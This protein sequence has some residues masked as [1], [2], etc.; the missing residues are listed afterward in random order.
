MMT[1]WKLLGIKGAALIVSVL[2]L[3]FSHMA[4]LNA[5]ADLRQEQADRIADQARAEQRVEDIE[6]QHSRNME[7]VTK[8]LTEDKTNAEEALANAIA[9][10]GTNKLRN[11]FYCPVVSGTPSAS[12]GTGEAPRAV[13]SREDEEFLVRFA[14]EADAAVIERNAAVEAYNKAREAQREGRD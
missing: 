5:K 3:I 14:A 6:T 8:K 7:T 4:Y 12:G 11:K 1:L 2:L 13:L 10:I 9:N